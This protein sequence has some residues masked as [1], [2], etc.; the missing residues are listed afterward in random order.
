MISSFIRAP[1]TFSSINDQRS[2]IMLTFIS[3]T[4]M[5]VSPA[6]KNTESHVKASG[7]DDDCVRNTSQ[8]GIIR[9]VEGLNSTPCSLLL[10]S[11]AMTTPAS[12]PIDLAMLSDR[13]SSPRP[14]LDT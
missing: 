6:R 5:I 7:L 14:A 13:Q 8:P 2:S 12:T 4:P 1:A 3:L 10:R 9:P 11:V